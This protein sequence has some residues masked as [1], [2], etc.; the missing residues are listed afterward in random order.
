[1]PVMSKT[2]F[3]RF[4][5]V[6]GLA[7]LVAGCTSIGPETVPRDRFDYG[8]AIAGSEK[9]QLLNNIVGLRYLEAPTF[10]HVASVI[11][12][13][14]LEGEVSLGGGLNTG[15]DVD[16]ADTLSVGGKGTWADRPT[17]TYTLLTGEEF[18]TNL[19][20][21][22]PPESIFALVQAGWPAELLLRLTVKTI[23]GVENAVASPSARRRA[24]PA[25]TEM[26]GAWTRLRKA[27]AIGFRRE[28]S[29]GA[30][31][32]VVYLSAEKTA[33]GVAGD[34][35]FLRRTLGLDPNAAEYRLHYGLVPDQASD[36]AVLTS[37]ILE[38]MNELAWR[39]DVPPEHI[40]EGRTVT[41]FA[42]NDAGT[43]FLIRIHHS[44]E[45]PEDSYAAVRVRDVWFY[46]DDRD[47]VS[48]R[49]FAMLQ[50][51]LSMTDPGD[52]ARG[53]VVTISN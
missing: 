34:I 11:N 18:A 43:A 48:K 15:F 9:E 27:R 12:S 40:E 7:L 49:T 30:A 28:A 1:M 24:D 35:A 47:V 29:G 33:P 13:Y 44:K 14:S 39:A 20:T 23:N 50:L 53:P 38:I 19:L 51:M 22:I 37:S 52:K 16:G 8:A 25:F 36:I 17:I 31:R 5:F 21:P 10:V 4:W 45:R 2:G 26:L 46:I 6:V 41:G 3:P 32:I 42:E